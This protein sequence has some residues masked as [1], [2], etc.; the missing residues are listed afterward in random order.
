MVLIAD[1]FFDFGVYAPL[2]VRM[3]YVRA[4]LGIYAE[5][6]FSLPGASVPSKTLVWLTIEPQ[7]LFHYLGELRYFPKRW[8]ELHHFGLYTKRY[9]V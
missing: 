6:M 4:V 1:Y 5:A 8:R 7:G 9:I 3:P 2:H